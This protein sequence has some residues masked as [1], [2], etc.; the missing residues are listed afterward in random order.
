MPL[1]TLCEQL[2]S[3]PTVDRVYILDPLVATGGTAIVSGALWL[4]ETRSD[5]LNRCQTCVG[6]IK[7]WGIPLDKIKLL[8]VLGS[9]PGLD[10]IAK[11]WPELEIW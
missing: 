5:L 3:E 4:Y 7:E 10:A 6:M 2:P 8:C 11:A 1:L 9:K